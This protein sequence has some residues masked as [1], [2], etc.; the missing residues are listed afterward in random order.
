ML[1][2]LPASAVMFDEYLEEGEFRRHLHLNISW[3]VSLIA[4]ITNNESQYPVV[5]LTTLLLTCVDAGSLCDT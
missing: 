2:D 5:N 4:S 1:T 3:T